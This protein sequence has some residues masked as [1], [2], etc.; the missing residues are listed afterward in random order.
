[1]TEGTVREATCCCG[2]L[3]IRLAG[4][5][6]YVSSCCCQACQRRSG[7][8]F[9]VTAFFAEGQVVETVGERSDYRRIGESGKP[10]DFH[11]CPKCGS[12][13]W[14]EPHA[15]PGRVAVAAGMFAD[16]AFPAP[17]RMIWTAH[18][19]PWVVTPEGLPLYDRAP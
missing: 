11:F 4:D 18:R 12:T 15:R 14:W 19:H 6:E 2:Q 13:V 5:P 16:A 3:K 10:L 9:A 7:S 1:M 17:Q 8:F